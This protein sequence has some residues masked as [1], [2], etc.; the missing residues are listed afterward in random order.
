[1]FENWFELKC[2]YQLWL[3]GQKKPFVGRGASPS[4]GRGVTLGVLIFASGDWASN[5]K[6]AS[7]KDG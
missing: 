4:V 2:I 3:K 6:R 5:R 1:M 7:G